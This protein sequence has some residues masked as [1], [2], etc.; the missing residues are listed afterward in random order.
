MWCAKSKWKYLVQSIFIKIVQSQRRHNIPDGG[1]KNFV[2]FKIEAV[3]GGVASDQHDGSHVFAKRPQ[4]DRLN[5]ILAFVVKNVAIVV[6]VVCQN[7]RGCSWNF[8]TERTWW[9]SPRSIFNRHFGE[10][11]GTDEIT[12]ILRRLDL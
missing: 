11:V 6:D 12:K 3:H 4:S 10:Y 9:N 2:P 8:Q 5:S 1:P 7:V